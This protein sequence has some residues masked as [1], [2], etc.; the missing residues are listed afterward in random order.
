M[1]ARFQETA[2]LKT[3][4][5]RFYALAEA[6]ENCCHGGLLL[7]EARTNVIQ[8]ERVRMWSHHFLSLMGNMMIGIFAKKVED[9][10][11]P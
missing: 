7:V 4:T 8:V 3:G 11:G 6:T 2:P 10:K 1:A 9:L 5:W